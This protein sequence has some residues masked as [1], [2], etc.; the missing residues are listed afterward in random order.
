MD[1]LNHALA[2]GQRTL[3]IVT[4]P[5]EIANARTSMLTANAR[6]LIAAVLDLAS[7]AVVVLLSPRKRLPKFLPKSE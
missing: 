5:R 1:V 7:R 4:V 2:T 3:I 6:E